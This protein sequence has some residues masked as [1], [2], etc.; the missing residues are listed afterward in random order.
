MNAKVRQK[1]DDILEN[2]AYISV[3]TVKPI[4]MYL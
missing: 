3:H 2:A 4:I 1:G